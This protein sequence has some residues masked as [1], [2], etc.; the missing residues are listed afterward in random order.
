[1]W[2]VIRSEYLLETPWLRVRKDDVVLPD[3]R[4]E[5]YY[6]T[7]RA[8]IVCVLPVLDDG[9]AVLVRQY[10]HGVGRITLELPAG[11]VDG[12]EAPRDAAERELREE[13]GCPRPTSLVHLGTVDQ[14]TSREATRLHAYLALG[15]PPPS[16]PDLEPTEA[17]SGLTV[18]LYPLDVLA[19]L[20]GESRVRAQSSVL[21]ILMARAREPGV[22]N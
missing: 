12:P 19:S 6:V 11:H 7:E 4:A 10:K 18:E 21:T 13:T 15:V 22:F 1:M 20:V 2:Q 8:D 5:P 14:D 17:L 16:V 9:Q 3:G